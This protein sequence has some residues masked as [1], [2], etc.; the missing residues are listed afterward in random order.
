MEL[1]PDFL[2]RMD[3]R[4]H[5]RAKLSWICAKFELLN[6]ELAKQAL[7]HIFGTILQ[8]NL[9]CFMFFISISEHNSSGSQS[10]QN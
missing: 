8:R 2:K 1:G 7:F 4:M 5:I 9:K 10:I 6:L 3:T